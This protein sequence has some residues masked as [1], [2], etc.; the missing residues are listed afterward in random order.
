ML[1]HYDGKFIVKKKT[2]R[3]VAKFNKVFSVSAGA[4]EY[5]VRHHDQAI[6]I[7]QVFLVD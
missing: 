6:L 5:G 7:S 2:I 3:K 1:L 4:S